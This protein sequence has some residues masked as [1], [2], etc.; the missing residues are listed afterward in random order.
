MENAAGAINDMTKRQGNS[1]IQ[2]KII[3]H[4]VLFVKWKVLTFYE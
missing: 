3:L 4:E 1:W 2:I